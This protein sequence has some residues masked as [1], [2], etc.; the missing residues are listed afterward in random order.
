MEEKKEEKE[1]KEEIVNL[2]EEEEE[3]F[4]KDLEED[5]VEIPRNAKI[6]DLIEIYKQI[7]DDI[8]EEPKHSDNHLSKMGKENLRKLVESVNGGNKEYV[9]DMGEKVETVEMV[10]KEKKK[11]SKITKKLK[12]K[13]GELLYRLNVGVAGIFEASMNLYDPHHKAV[14]VRGLT[15]DYQQ[16]EI[17]KEFVECYGEACEDFPT[18]CKYITHWASVATINNATLISQRDSENKDCKKKEL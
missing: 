11:G 2:E 6:N 4:K 1:E 3:D 17:K 9:E 16:P 10:G 14:D 12:K 13:T 7:C 18:L 8:G 5:C 15:L